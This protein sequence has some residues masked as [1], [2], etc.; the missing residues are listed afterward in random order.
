MHVGLYNPHIK[1]PKHLI[2][3]DN[4]SNINYINVPFIKRIINGLLWNNF[5]NKPFLILY[6]NTPYQ[7]MEQSTRSTFNTKGS[8]DK[9]YVHSLYNSTKLIKPNP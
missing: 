4:T 3:V 5:R 8:T 7:R 2:K 1:N 6:S 9:M